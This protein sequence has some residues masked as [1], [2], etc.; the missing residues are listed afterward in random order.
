MTVKPIKIEKDYQDAI[1]R[2]EVIFDAKKGSANG[3]E[4]EILGILTEKYE[5]EHFPVG[6]RH[7]NLP[8]QTS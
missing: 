3:D 5:D 8:P 7:I 6:S 4:L 1:G 2:L